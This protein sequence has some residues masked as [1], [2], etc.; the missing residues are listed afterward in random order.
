METS[1]VRTIVNTPGRVWYALRRWP[2]IPAF[3]LTVLSSRV[4]VR[5]IR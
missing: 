4:L 3:I 2:I 5:Y 1:A